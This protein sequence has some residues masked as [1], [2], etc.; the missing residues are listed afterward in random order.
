MFVWLYVCRSASQL[1]CECFRFLFVVFWLLRI[2]IVLA[3][4]ENPVY[5]MK[6]KRA[7]VFN[8]SNTHYEIESLQH[9]RVNVNVSVFA[10]HAQTL[11]SVA[12]TVERT[13]HCIQIEGSTAVARSREVSRSIDDEK[14]ANKQQTRNASIPHD[15]MHQIND[16]IKSVS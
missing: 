1:M 2:A 5:P 14:K 6:A 8:G 11:A 13:K 7:D 3:H 16:M 4:S 12:S 10:N 9:K 15:L